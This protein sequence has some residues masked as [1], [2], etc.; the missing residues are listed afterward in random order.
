MTGFS[1]IEYFGYYDED[2]MLAPSLVDAVCTSNDITAQISVN[3]YLAN[4]VPRY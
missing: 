4:E 3:E 2:A 1:N